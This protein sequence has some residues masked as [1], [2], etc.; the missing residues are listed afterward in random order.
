MNKMK[1]FLVTYH[2]PASAMAQMAGA[3]PEQQ[4]EGMKQWMDW[5]A[6]AGEHLVDMGSPLMPGQ[7]I[8]SGGN[9]TQS[10]KEFSGYSILQAENM[11]QAKSLLEGHPHINGWNK[12]ATI[13]LS[14]TMAIPGM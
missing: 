9:A 11:E 8:H 4:A 12:D 10:N 13:E 5:A 6:R 2:V 7:Q 3:T 1:K 14:E